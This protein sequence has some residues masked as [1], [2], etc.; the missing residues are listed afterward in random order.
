MRESQKGV[1]GAYQRS[2]GEISDSLQS[3]WSREPLWP[4]GS[5]AESAGLGSDTRSLA[6]GARIRYP[7][8]VMSHATSL[9]RESPKL[10]WTLAVG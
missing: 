5:V 3:A 7:T 8:Q 1:E 4:W 6:L 10:L 2:Y 9:F